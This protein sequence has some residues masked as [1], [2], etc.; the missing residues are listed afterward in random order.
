MS[1]VMVSSFWT[2]EMCLDLELDLMI[3]MGA[4][5]FENSTI[6]LLDQQSTTASSHF[7]LLC[8]ETVRANNRSTG[9]RR[10]PNV[11]LREDVFESDVCS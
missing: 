11:F 7:Y 5:H 1:L 2:E 10:D 8:P 6:P 4:F 3:L 9:W